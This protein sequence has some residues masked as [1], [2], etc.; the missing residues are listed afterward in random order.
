MEKITLF[1]VIYIIYKKSFLVILSIFFKKRREKKSVS[2]INSLL[3]FKEFLLVNLKS[4]KNKQLKEEQENLGLK[5]L[6]YLHCDSLNPTTVF[7][8]TGLNER[9]TQVSSTEPDKA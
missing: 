4:K 7:Y 3:N 5:N 9:K 2:R 1:L 8:L 6:T